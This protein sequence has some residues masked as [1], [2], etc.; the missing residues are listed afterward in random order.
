MRLPREARSRARHATPALSRRD[1][2]RHALLASCL[3]LTGGA[4]AGCALTRP[5]TGGGEAAFLLPLTGPAASLGQNM[6][7][8]ASL[9]AGPDSPP[10]VFDTQDTAAGAAEAARRALAGGARMLLGPLRADQ[11]P[12]VLAVA[13]RVPVV[14][15]S[16]DDRLTA[17]GAFVFGITPAQSVATAF[18]YARAQGLG[19]IAL[20]AAPGPLGAA[21]AEAARLIAAAGGLTLAT[22]L[23]R[24]DATGLAADLGA[25]GALPEAVFLPDGG[26]ALTAFADA[27]SGSGIQLMGGVQWGV[28]DVAA[29]PALAGAW[30]AAPPLERFLPFVETFETRFGESPGIVAALGHDAALMAS[31]LAQT[32]ALDRAGLT[33]EGGFRGALGA[34]RFDADGRCLRDLAVLTIEAGQIVP[35]GEVAGT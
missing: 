13:G 12:A 17:E 27:L 24:D 20:V 1:L 9:A 30:F 25:G 10:P 11:T 26:P 7:R 31:L 6:S 22:V 21:S 34:F 3:S 8:A 29:Q 4:F 15:F 14:T 35:I 2:C 16:N 23:L 32:R 5:L 18:S 19:R 28:S 33:R